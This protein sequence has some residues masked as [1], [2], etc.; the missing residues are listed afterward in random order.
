VS[1]VWTLSELVHG[2][3]T[4]RAICDKTTDFSGAKEMSTPTDFARNYCQTIC[5]K[6]L[7]N[8]FLVSSIYVLC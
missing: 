1:S 6:L 5:M 4:Q 2:L 8:D 3:Q 7:S